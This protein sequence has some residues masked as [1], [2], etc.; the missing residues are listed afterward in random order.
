MCSIGRR[1]PGLQAEHRHAHISWN[2]P[3]PDARRPRDPG[4]RE[5]SSADRASIVR[6]RWTDSTTSRAARPSEHCQQAAS[7]ERVGSYSAFAL[8]LR[9][10]ETIICDKGYAGAG[11]ADH[12]ATQDNLG[13][14]THRARTLHRLRARTAAKLLASA[15]HLAQLAHSAAPPAPSPTSPPNPGNQPSSGDRG[16]WARRPMMSTIRGTSR[17]PTRHDAVL[18][19]RT[20]RSCVPDAASARSSRPLPVEEQA[21][22]RNW[23]RREQHSQPSLLFVVPGLHWFGL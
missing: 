6:G 12:A 9:G 15:R 11:F 18:A 23:F 7:E 4:P 5:P 16:S 2:A 21:S 22:G 8:A 3:V 14:E 19:H 1:P 10:G 17:R 13:L 20:K